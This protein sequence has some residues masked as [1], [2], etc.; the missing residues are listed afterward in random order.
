VTKTSRM[1]ACCVTFIFIAWGTITSA[2]RFTVSTSAASDANPKPAFTSDADDPDDPNSAGHFSGRVTGPNGKPLSSA[3][4]FIA[5]FYDRSSVIGPVRATTD[6]EGRFEF[7]APDMTYTTRDGLPAR[8]EGLLIVTKEGYAPD[9]LRTWGHDKTGMHEYW[10]PVKGAALDLQLATDDVPIHGQFLGPDCR[11]LAGARVRLVDLMIPRNRDLDAHLAHWS[12]ASVTEGFLTKVPDYKQELWHRPDLV[13]GLTIET[14]TDSDGRFTLSGL[15]RDRLAELS[16]SAAS[17]VDTILTVMTRDAPDVGTFLDFA[18]KP[19]QVIHGAGFT[20]ELKPGLTIT[21]RVID[22]DS[23]EPISG[24]WVGPLQNALNTLTSSLYP[25]RTDDDG[26]FT[27]TGLDPN[28]LKYEEVHRTIVAAATPGLPYQTMWVVAKENE[29]VVIECPR[30]IPFHLL[31]VDDRGPVEA[32]VTYVDVQP[33]ANVVHD[34]VIWPISRAA[35]NANGTYDGFVLP[36]PGAIL[37]RT[38]SDLNYR[39]ACVDAKA[40]FAPGKTDWTAEERISAYGTQDLLTTCNGRYVNTVYRG[41]TL[42]Q[43]DY[44]AIVLVNPAPDS[45][46]LELAATVVRDRPRRVSLVDE[47]GKPVAGAV[48]H[49]TIQWTGFVVATTKAVV[50]LQTRSTKL[51]S[52]SFALTRLHHD[53]V[54]HVTFVQ[55][56]RQL[57]GLLLARGDSDEPYT[58]Q[59]QRWGTI[60][61]RI[62]DDHDEP[63]SGAFIEVLA[64]GAESCER[65]GETTDANGQFRVAKVIPGLSYSGKVYAA[66]RPVGTAFEKLVVGAGELRELGDVRVDPSANAQ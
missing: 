16:V 21:G 62:V 7:D 56:D 52:A 12:K 5:R 55:E 40:F 44:T 57:I 34:E 41:P 35:R 3:R 17:V 48:M 22:R 10:D 39:P 29:E 1:L 28:I 60:A 37:V 30:G 36:G 45:P 14:R 42:D 25:W 53:R 19:T 66:R 4:V 58:V 51:P 6:A 54:Q 31:V 50:S 13:P 26:R 61:G 49:E 33:N 15:G 47:S 65:V 32:E 9:W 64:D 8:R 46:P 43:R 59:M 27:I 20:V 11:P 23:R 38:K 63:V 18:G 24:M 2:T